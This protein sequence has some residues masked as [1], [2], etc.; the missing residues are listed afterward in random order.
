M[1]NKGQEA[2]MQRTRVA[3]TMITEAPGLEPCRVLVCVE[4]HPTSPKC[5][6]THIECVTKVQGNYLVT[7]HYGL[8]LDKAFADM[9]ARLLKQ[10]QLMKT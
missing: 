5:Y 6:S 10:T 8:T 2:T 1:L 3:E 7:G 4:D 9:G